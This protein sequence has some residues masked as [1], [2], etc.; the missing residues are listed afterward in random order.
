LKL[1]GESIE[2]AP[3]ELAASIRGDYLQGVGKL[4]DRLVIVLN[5]QSLLSDAEAETLDTV[6][7]MPGRAA[8][9]A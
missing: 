7:A 9:S 4:D 8:S 1:S 6:S 2:P 5:L 3:E